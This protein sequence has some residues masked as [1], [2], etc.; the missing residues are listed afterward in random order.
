MRVARTAQ[1]NLVAVKRGAVDSHADSKDLLGAK[2]LGQATS[3]NLH[4]HISQEEG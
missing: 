2:D 1:K 4:H 3:G